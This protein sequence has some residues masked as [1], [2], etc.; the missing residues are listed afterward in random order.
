MQIMR[1]TVLILSFYR[2]AGALNTFNLKDLFSVRE[3]EMTNLERIKILPKGVIAFHSSLGVFNSQKLVLYREMA[4][5]CQRLDYSCEN[6]VLALNFKNGTEEKKRLVST[7]RQ[8]SWL[9]K[10]FLQ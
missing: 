8:G 3:E 2:T 5:L 10:H 6:I 9:F 7:A 4:V 1:D